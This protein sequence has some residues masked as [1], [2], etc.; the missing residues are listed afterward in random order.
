M[1]WTAL[2]RITL[3]S[4]KQCTTG[5]PKLNDPGVKE[6]ITA[7]LEALLGSV[8]SQIEEFERMGFIVVGS[9]RWTIED[10]FLT[11]TMKIRRPNI[12]DLYT[13]KTEAFYG[14]GQKVIWE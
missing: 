13:A 10:G 6:R 2:A 3:K 9:T 7:D 8:N 11:P 1:P 12:E 4:G 5:L 14:A